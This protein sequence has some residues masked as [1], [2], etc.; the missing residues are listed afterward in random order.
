[1]NYVTSTAKYIFATDKIYEIKLNYFDQEHNINL[2]KDD[3]AKIVFLT[4]YQEK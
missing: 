2:T 4:N 1:M 3:C